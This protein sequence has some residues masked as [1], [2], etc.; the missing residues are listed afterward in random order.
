MALW[1]RTPGSRQRF[2]KFAEEL[3]PGLGLD[4]PAEQREEFAFAG[5]RTRQIAAQGRGARL[6]TSDT[7]TS[8]RCKINQTN[9]PP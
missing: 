6:D 4:G 5:I 9:A 1:L 2:E 8:H 7:T 3:A